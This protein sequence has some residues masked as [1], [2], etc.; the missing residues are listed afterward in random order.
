ML[1]AIKRGRSVLIGFREAKELFP[2]AT[3][4]PLAEKQIGSCMVMVVSISS[5]EPVRFAISK[6]HQLNSTGFQKSV[7][8]PL[9]SY[10]GCLT[11]RPPRPTFSSRIL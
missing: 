4:S 5:L 8:V 10:I 2:K 11:L 7:E 3:C 6:A 1:Q 9:F